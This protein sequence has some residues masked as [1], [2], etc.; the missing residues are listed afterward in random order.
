MTSCR[1]LSSK[2][3]KLD[4]I[5]IF[6]YQGF[7]STNVSRQLGVYESSVRN[8]IRSIVIK[9]MGSFQGSGK[10]SPYIGS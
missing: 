9:N 6:L 5:K 1:K 7:N 8:W 3:F 10:L 4:A 2:E